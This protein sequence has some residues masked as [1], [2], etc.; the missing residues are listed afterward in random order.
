[1]KT[2][3]KFNLPLKDYV[4]VAI[5]RNA[6]LLQVA[7]Q[8]D[9]VLPVTIQ[10]WAIVDTEEKFENKQ[11]RIAGTGHKLTAEEAQNYIGTVFFK[12]LVFHVFTF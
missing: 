12:A 8:H 9:Y 3:W 1:M 4:T 10:L 11:F 5:P 7:V 2:V 6:K